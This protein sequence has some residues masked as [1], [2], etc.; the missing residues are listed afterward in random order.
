MPTLRVRNEAT[1]TTT[2]GRHRSDA[3][4]GECASPQ[5]GDSHARRRCKI[6]RAATPVAAGCVPRRA[7]GSARRKEGGVFPTCGRAGFGAAFGPASAGPSFVWRRPFRVAQAC[8]RGAGFQPASAL[9]QARMPALRVRNEATATTTA[10]RHRSDAPTRE[11]ASPQGG[12]SHARPRCRTRR[13]ATPVAAGCVPRRAE[14]SAR[15][16]EGGVFL[17]CG[18]AGFGAAFGPASAGP[19][20]R[21]AQASSLR[22]PLGRQGCLP[23]AGG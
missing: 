18:R 10:G 17:N 11:C 4:T 16:K 19:S 22:L 5:G 21:V 13:A 9:G 12:D 20:F 15:R 3:P 14:G 1:A 2:A 23:Y 8:L 7:E 6:R